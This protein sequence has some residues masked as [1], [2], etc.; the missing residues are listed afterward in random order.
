MGGIGPLPSPLSL[1]RGARESTLSVRGPPHALCD[2]RPRPSHGGSGW[3]PPEDGAFARRERK[4]NGEE[5]RGLRGGR[6]RPPR[7]LSRQP[8]RRKE[9][10]AGV[11]SRE[12]RPSR[13]PIAE[14]EE[15]SAS[16]QPPRASPRRVNP[17]SDARADSLLNLPSP[18]NR[19]AFTRLS[20]THLSLF[21]QRST[22]ST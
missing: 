18:A 16:P 4:R 6:V 15:G 7:D 17:W 1:G 13:S 12:M 8:P 22:T 14:L 10:T 20:P 19:A 2:A 21:S 9:A 5:G 3:K 11:L